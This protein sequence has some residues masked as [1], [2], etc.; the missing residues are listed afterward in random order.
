MPNPYASFCSDFYCNMRLVSHM[1]LP[2]SR[3]TL[4]HFFELITRHYPAMARLRTGNG[5]D[6]SLEEDR[7]GG[8][9][10]WLSVE[11][12][13]L[14]SG[15][16]NP[17]SIEQALALHKLVLSQAPFQLGI[18]Q[19]EIDHLDLLLGFDLE[20][21]G[22]H[23]EVI[24]ESLFAGSPLAGLLDE[25]GTQAVDFQPSVT[26]ALREDCRLQARVDIVTRTNSAQIRTGNYENDAISV[27]LTVKRF[28]GDRPKEPLE[29]LVEELAER[30]SALVESHLLTRV[31]K[32]I[33]E[34]IASRS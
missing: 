10:R 12:R 5:G 8:A 13:R 16:V 2:G 19:I 1:Q 26:V 17:D 22:N 27:Y 20:Y 15:Q 9:Y 24:A 23:D 3:E 11:P 7:A 6:F 31:V 4:L 33:S 30:A 32:P 14:S 28:W 29:Q 21:G 18:S 25:P 34:A